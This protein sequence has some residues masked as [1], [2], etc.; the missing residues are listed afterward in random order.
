MRC[1]LE[2]QKKE[3]SMKISKWLIALFAMLVF[4]GCEKS[5][6]QKM[7]DAANDMQKDAAQA[8]DGMKV[9]SMK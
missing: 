3:R 8:V 1:P 2:L 9:P 7:E 5:D 4:V 6:E